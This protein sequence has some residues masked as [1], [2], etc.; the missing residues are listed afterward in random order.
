MSSLNTSEIHEEKT[1]AAKNSV[2]WA[3]FLTIIKIFAGVFTGS[4]GI[5]SEA[6]HSALDLCAAGI[7]FFA[8]KTA[9]KPADSEHPYGHEKI[10]NLS[11]LAE[12]ALLVI[13]CG[14][15]I[16]EAINR[17]IFDDVELMLTWW[18]FAVVIISIIV[19]IN[20]SSMLRKVAKK[21]KSQALEADALH[22][23][24]DIWSSCVVLFGLACVQISELFPKESFLHQ[25]LAK[26]D[27]LAALGVAGIVLWVAW[28]LSKRAIHSLMDGGSTTQTEMVLTLMKSRAPEYPVKRIRLRDIGPKAF[29]EM[30]IATPGELHVEEAHEVTHFIEEIIRKELPD[31]DITIHIEPADESNSDS[32]DLTAHRLAIRHHLRIHGFREEGPHGSNHYF[33]DVEMPPNQTLKEAH[34]QMLSYKSD[35]INALDSQDIICRIEPNK[36]YISP[37]ARPKEYTE[38]F[39]VRL[40]TDT[41]NNHINIIQVTHIEF[42]DFGAVTTLSCFAT[43][44]HDLNVQEAHLI[45]SELEKQLHTLFPFLSRT[46]VLLS[47]HEL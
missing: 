37:G 25:I 19:D 23:T 43:A 12:T 32:S 29:I 30:D 6:L 14:W 31:A 38:D 16:Y 3:T 8:V 7:T 15:I 5:L 22:F 36:R 35:M 26:A 2:L 27:A 34:E 21:T 28:G 33:M 39:I 47:P 20:R 24:T 1:S 10:E 11:A 45:A 9:A 44:K 4:L 41:L 13:T 42:Q 46:S 18:A 17:L 40:A